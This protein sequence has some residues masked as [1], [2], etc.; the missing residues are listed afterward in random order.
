M[1]TKAEE[2]YEVWTKGNERKWRYG[3]KKLGLVDQ[4]DINDFLRLVRKNELVWDSVMLGKFVSLVL[5]YCYSGKEIHL[6]VDAV[7]GDISVGEGLDWEGD[8]YVR[9][10]V[11]GYV[12]NYMRRGKIVVEG[13]IRESVGLYMD[14]GTVIVFGDVREN[15]GM[16][17]K[18]GMVFIEGNVKKGEVGNEM[19]GGCIIVNGSVGDMV[20]SDMYGGTIIIRGCVMN[21]VG[22]KMGNGFIIVDGFVTG[23]VGEPVYGGIIVVNGEVKIRDKIEWLKKLDIGV[24][25]CNGY[26]YTGEWSDKS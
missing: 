9:G 3:L 23:E 16:G 10:N 4:E 11:N 19:S 15:V 12:G 17:M 13:E 7:N 22:W 18:N 2:L 8:I 14:G 6:D 26:L 25:L 21:H 1:R 20:G 24:I 5:K